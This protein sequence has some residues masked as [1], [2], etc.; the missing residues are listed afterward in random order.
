ME[1]NHSFPSDNTQVK[2]ICNVHPESELCSG[3]KKNNV[4]Q[5]W[6]LSL[7]VF[8][9]NTIPAWPIYFSPKKG[10]LCLK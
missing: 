10:I 8:P 1:K 4:M 2:D 7:Q 3:R 5:E 6:S 9:Y